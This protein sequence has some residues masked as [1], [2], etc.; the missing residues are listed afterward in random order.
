MLRRKLVSFEDG[1]VVRVNHARL[2][3]AEFNDG[4]NLILKTVF[5]QRKFFAG[6]FG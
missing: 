3:V 6:V 1:L 2:V 4:V 5:V